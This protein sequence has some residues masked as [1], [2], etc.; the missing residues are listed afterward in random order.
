MPE[1]ATVDWTSGHGHDVEVRQDGRVLRVDAKL[2]WTK[3]AP[4]GFIYCS[5]LKLKDQ[6][7]YPLDF[8]ALVVLEREAVKVEYD[9]PKPGMVRLAAEA[10][11]E[12]IYFLPAPEVPRLLERGAL[13]PQYKGRWRIRL[14][15]LARYINA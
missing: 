4:T 12:T 8:F 1:D 14:D 13:L 15:C 3:G 6:K 10:S 7:K 2:A 5:P 9:G 11:S